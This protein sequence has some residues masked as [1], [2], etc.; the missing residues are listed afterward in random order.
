MAWDGSLELGFL[1][2][3]DGIMVNGIMVD[4]EWEKESKVEV[5]RERE[6]RTRFSTTLEVE[7]VRG[8]TREIGA[9]VVQTNLG[10][11]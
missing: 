6:I 7:V 8:E 2:T 1:G 4:W 11:G 3:S 10:L 5:F 9:A